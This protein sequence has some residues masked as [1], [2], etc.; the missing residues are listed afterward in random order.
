MKWIFILILLGGLLIGPLHAQLPFAV[1]QAIALKQAKEIYA[2]YAPHDSDNPE[3]N[4]AIHDVSFFGHKLIL[5]DDLDLQEEVED[6]TLISSH[7]VSVAQIFQKTQAP[8][9]GRIKLLTRGIYIE[10]FIKAFASW[11]KHGVKLVN[12]SMSIRSPEIISLLNEFIRGGGIVIASSGNSAQNLGLQ[13]PYHYE[14]FLGLTVSASNVDG[15]LEN[16]SQWSE[17]SIVAPGSIDLYPVKRLAYN[18]APK[19][20]P[21]SF[22]EG[23]FLRDHLFGMT[24]AASPVVAAVVTLALRLKPDLTQKQVNYAILT[25]AKINREGQALFD[26]E[27]FMLQVL[28]L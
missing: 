26:A 12:L 11:K 6:L 4:V 21:E 10:D 25:S 17:T 15:N 3:V 27:R 5:N 24:S 16:F 9:Q 14:D 20:E 23:L 1:E 2:Q 8:F 19:K 13:L 22:K 28:S 18:I 7:G